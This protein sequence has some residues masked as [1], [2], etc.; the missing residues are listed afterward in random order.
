MQVFNTHVKVAGEQAV[1]HT[2]Y[3]LALM[4]ATNYIHEVVY[5]NNLLVLQ[6]LG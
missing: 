2:S 4:L 3:I 6:G 1:F 5:A